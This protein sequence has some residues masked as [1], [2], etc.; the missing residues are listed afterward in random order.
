MPRGAD[1]HFN[2]NES[3][4]VWWVARAAASIDARNWRP[5][6]ASAK[7]ETSANL[8]NFAIASLRW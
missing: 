3:A 2:G 4:A 7:E 1:K 6:A 5:I 8:D